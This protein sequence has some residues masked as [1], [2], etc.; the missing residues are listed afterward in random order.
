MSSVVSEENY[1][2]TLISKIK[3]QTKP[4]KLKK[5]LKSLRN[6][7]IEELKGFS[8]L[9]IKIFKEEKEQEKKQ[10]LKIVAPIIGFQHYFEDFKKTNLKSEVNNIVE[11]EGENTP[12]TVDDNE[13]EVKQIDSSDFSDDE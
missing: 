7:A 4:K 2:N 3:E 9:K 10:E 8:E 13:E 12:S 5:H 11:Y 6:L 1:Q